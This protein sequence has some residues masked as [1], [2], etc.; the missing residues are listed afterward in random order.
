MECLLTSRE[1]RGTSLVTSSPSRGPAPITDAF[2]E[3]GVAFLQLLALDVVPL[4]FFLCNILPICSP[5]TE[6]RIC[7]L[8]ASVGLV[9]EMAQSGRLLIALLALLIAL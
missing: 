7:L 9:T 4:A 8:D 1:F 5:F 2:H 6:S 3:S